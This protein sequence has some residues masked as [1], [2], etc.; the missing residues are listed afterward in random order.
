M[1]F[2]V[3]PIH[4]MTH[5]QSQEELDKREEYL[6]RREKELLAKQQRLKRARDEVSC[7][8]GFIGH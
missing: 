6:D 3:V 1:W 8:R 7:V 4:Q 5:E 2:N